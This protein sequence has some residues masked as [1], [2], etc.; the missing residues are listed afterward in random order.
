M[1]AGGCSG[2]TCPARRSGISCGT[3]RAS[4]PS[5]DGA[6]TAKQAEYSYYPGLDNPHALIVGSTQYFAHND[7]LG[8]VIALTDTA[9][10]LQRTYGFSPWGTL[11][12][13]TDVAGFAGKD[14]ARFKGALWLGPEA[15]VYY[16]RARWYEPKTGRF[17]SEDPIGLA[18][19]INLYAFAA[20]DPV[21]GRDP[22]GLCAINE[23]LW[24]RYV[25]HYNA[26]GQLVAITV[27]GYFCVPTGSPGGGEI[28]GV[29]AR[30]VEPD[31]CPGVPVA[32][33]GANINANIKKA[34]SASIAVQ[35]GNPLVSDAWFFLKVRKGGDWD[36][37]AA[38]DVFDP[39]GNF[40]YGA[41]GL[42]AG[43]SASTLLRMS[44]WAAEQYDA[45]RSGNASLLRALFGKPYPENPGDR[46]S[47]LAG[48]QYYRNG[49]DQR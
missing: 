20:D 22:S 30:R 23:E 9:K 13:G 10:V 12:G 6:G 18:G 39:F 32:P 29:K 25:E 7:G 5:F 2:R 45:G 28:D 24:V 42:A 35:Y 36:Y 34:R 41:T 49:C 3:A 43:Y 38:G 26:E 17:L 33:A 21:N 19:G 40:N 44:G 16:M 47:I 15:E 48:M 37:K 27:L 1:P 8:N 31:E 46:A 11:N 14:R 4:W